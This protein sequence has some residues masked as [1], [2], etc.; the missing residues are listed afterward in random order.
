MQ[1]S[2]MNPMPTIDVVSSNWYNPTLSYYLFMVPGILV[3]LV[4]LVG[5]NMTALNIVQEKEIG[6]IEQ[7]NVTP[8]K[9]VSFYFGKTYSLLGDWFCCIYHRIDYCMGSI[10]HYPAGK[11]CFVISFPF[12]IPNCHYGFWVVDFHLLP[13]P[14]SRHSRLPF[15]LYRYLTL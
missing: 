5:G 3:L 2:T 10:W 11:Y 14:S 9:K 7:I 13:K 12:G 1:P 6:T 15:S 8:G 4:T